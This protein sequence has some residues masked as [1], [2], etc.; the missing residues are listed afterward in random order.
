MWNFSDGG[1]HSDISHLEQMIQRAYDEGVRRIRVHAVFDGRDV[2]PQSEPKYIKRLEKFCAGFKDADF[3]IASGGGREIMVA[4]RYENDWGKVK[5]GWDA[6]VHGKA[7]REFRSATEA[8]KTLRAE[9]PKVQDQYL[10]AFV[11]VENT[12]AKSVLS[13]RAERAKSSSASTSHGAEPVGKVHD[14]DAFIYYDFRADRA[15]EFS[16]A[17]VMDE[18]DKF[19]H[20]TKNQ[21]I[22][23]GKKTL[24]QKFFMLA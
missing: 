17:F 11:I 14:G 19:D 16:E 1:V 7:P 15:V 4:D 12:A 6:I 20:S 5:L 2:A 22:T 21:K 23:D 24:R 3:R 18:F 10:P 9:D 13:S 8:I